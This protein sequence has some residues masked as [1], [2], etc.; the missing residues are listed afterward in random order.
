[1]KRKLIVL[2]VPVFFLFFKSS[3]QYKDLEGVFFGKVIAFGAG[4]SVLLFNEKQ[5]G[6]QATVTPLTYSV[7]LNNKSIVSS[8]I[9]LHRKYSVRYDGNDGLN[10]YSQTVNFKFFEFES[11]YRAAL[12]KDGI[13]K[14]S[15]V[16]FTLQAGF[17]IGNQKTNDTRYGLTGDEPSSEFYLGLGPTIYQRLGSKAILFAEPAYRFVIKP[18]MFKVYLGDNNEKLVKLNHLSCHIG[19]MFLVGKGK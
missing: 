4:G 3:A 9:A 18:G 6:T 10:D 7:I 13:E 17:L 2:F 16:F 1:M 15:S 12:T 19:I 11:A 8:R 5:I 14:P